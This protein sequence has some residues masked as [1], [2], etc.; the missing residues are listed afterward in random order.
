MAAG[1]CAAAL[2]TLDFFEREPV[3]ENVLRARA[4]SAPPGSAGSRAR[5]D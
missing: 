5:F 3:L 1:G 4:G 2:A